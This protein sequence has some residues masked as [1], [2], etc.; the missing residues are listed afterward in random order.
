MAISEEHAL[1][2][3]HFRQLRWSLQALAAAGSDQR[4]LFPDHIVTADELAF[5]FDHWAGVIRSTYEQDLSRPQ[6]ESLAAIDR[7]LAT[8]SREGVEFDLELWTEAALSTSEHWAGVRRLARS[9]LEAFGWT[10]ES[11][12]ENPDDLGTL[13]GL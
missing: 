12:V 8:M 6:A 2:S 5:D 10:L 3:W 13:F 4:T 7:K 9:A 1:R 11:S